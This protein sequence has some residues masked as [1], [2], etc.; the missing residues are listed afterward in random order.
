LATQEIFK[1]NPHLEGP[2]SKHQNNPTL[3]NIKPM[4]N[5][6]LEKGEKPLEFSNTHMTPIR[7]HEESTIEILQSTFEHI[8]INPLFD[9]PPSINGNK[10]LPKYPKRML[11]IELNQIMQQ[12]YMP[13]ETCTLGMPNIP[14]LEENQQLTSLLLTLP[15]TMTS[16]VIEPHMCTPCEI[17]I[18]KTPIE[19]QRKSLI[20]ISP[21]PQR[22]TSHCQINMMS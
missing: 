6:D 7:S 18:A 4:I 8:N 11:R 13:K 9:K 22:N 15:T 5:L 17:S 19:I 2:K 14:P 16:N 1:F 3:E 20:D 21:I 12:K 10:T